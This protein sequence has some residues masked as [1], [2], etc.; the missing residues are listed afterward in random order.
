MENI[1]ETEELLYNEKEKTLDMAD[2]LY[3]ILRHWRI[4][5]LLGIVFAALLGYKGI[6]PDIKEKT[7]EE[8]TELRNIQRSYDKQLIDYENQVNSYEAKK[9]T[10]NKQMKLYEKALDEFDKKV[11]I[12]SDIME[13]YSKYMEFV[14]KEAEEKREYLDKSV[15]LNLDPKHTSRAS[16][17]YSVKLGDSEWDNYREGMPD[18]VDEIVSAYTNNINS[19]ID[20]NKLGRD[21]KVDPEYVQELVAI[22]SNVDSNRIYIQAYYSDIPGAEKIMMS[23]ITQLSEIW[24][25]Y[26]KEL[27]AHDLIQ[28]KDKSISYYNKDI[29]KKRK[30]AIDQLISFENQI[31]TLQKNKDT[32]SVTATPEPPIDPGSPPL[33]PLMPDELQQ[34]TESGLRPKNAVKMGVIGMALGIILGGFIF[35]VIY[36]MDGLL[37]TGTEL[38]KDY[39]LDI[40]ADIQSET[41][42]AKNGID[43][44]IARLRG[45]R[46]SREECLKRCAILIKSSMENG[47]LLLTGT[48]PKED[49]YSFTEELK[50]R[51]PGTEIVA[52][53]S[54]LINSD[55]LEKIGEVKD[56]LILEKKNSSRH[57]DI[58]AEL[59]CIRKQKGRI[60]GAVTI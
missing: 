22:W 15:Y 60:I 48:I 13:N 40:F 21:T 41:K 27:P 28:L 54:A 38:Q 30:E 14:N 5:L 47:R 55:T 20:W 46:L 23:L 52:A 25:E 1:R 59:D 56:V 34:E 10:Y 7:A 42:E 24:G 32:Y 33:E 49:I 44:R 16:T 18:P 19:V 37:H 39:G 29:E 53:E 26:R 50:D 11:E 9:R 4:L 35:A 45:V 31:A 6:Q 43:R 12:N 57:K 2:F 17:I 36:V 58:A 3:S 51:L 8:L